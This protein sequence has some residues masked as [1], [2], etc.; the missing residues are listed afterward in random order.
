M[1]DAQ[2]LRDSIDE[3]S[4]TQERAVL[5]CLGV[6]ASDSSSD[7]DCGSTDESDSEVGTEGSQTFKLPEMQHLTSIVTDS[8]YNW[9]EIVDK[10]VSGSEGVNQRHVSESCFA[11][12]MEL[13]LPTREEK[14]LRHSYEAF[15][16]DLLTG[17]WLTN[18]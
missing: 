6:D 1:R 9:F 8:R 12:V 16:H 3:L 13:G 11:A 18:G 10:V 17:R 5:R 2:A 14:L 15:C 7:D 4:L